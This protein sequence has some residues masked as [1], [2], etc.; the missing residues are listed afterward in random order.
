MGAAVEKG[1]PMWCPV[2]A[3]KSPAIPAHNGHETCIGCG[4]DVAAYRRGVKS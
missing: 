3:R 4:F 1:H 2:Y